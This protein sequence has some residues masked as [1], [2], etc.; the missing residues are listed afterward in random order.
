MNLNNKK[1]NKM[2]TLKFNSRNMR[3]IL[4]VFP[5]MIY[6]LFFFASCQKENVITP[7]KENIAMAERKLEPVDNDVVQSDAA[8]VVLSHPIITKS[9]LMLKIDHRAAMSFNP[10]Y[11]VSVSSD[12]NVE[13]EGRR[14][15][16][17]IGKKKLKISSNEVQMLKYLFIRTEFFSM[18]EDI[19]NII[20]LPIVYTTYSEQSP[21]ADSEKTLRDDNS[22][23]PLQ[24]FSLRVQAE[25]ILNISWLI[26]GHDS[27]KFLYSSDK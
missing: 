15:V 2:K 22:G 12:G 13:F 20:D 19:P 18:N 24:L 17:F 8:D 21:A 14:N 9:Y 1:I 6:S 3:D 27:A 25:S 16:F 26:N 10:D 23:Q 11:S 5:L 7:S 4:L